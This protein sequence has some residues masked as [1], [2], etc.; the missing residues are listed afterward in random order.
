MIYKELYRFEIKKGRGPFMEILLT[1]CYMKKKI[2]VPLQVCIIEFECDEIDS[3]AIR[4]SKTLG[5]K[6]GIH[7]GMFA[8]VKLNG[9]I[10]TGKVEMIPQQTGLDHIIWL[11]EQYCRNNDFVSGDWVEL[12]FPEL[13]TAEKVTIVILPPL[14]TP[15]SLIWQKSIKST[16]VGEKIPL[17]KG[18]KFAI[19]TPLL[20]KV[21]VKVIS[22]EPEGFL[23]IEPQTEFIVNNSIGD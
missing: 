12:S 22:T 8:Q 21:T 19:H 18:S 23:L 7:N 17:H 5:T 10:A 6:I 4:I 11:T 20:S 1:Y 3:T 16:L 13:S 14:T 9:R 15:N 2:K